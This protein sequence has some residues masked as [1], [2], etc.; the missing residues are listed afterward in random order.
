MFLT[1]VDWCIVAGSMATFIFVAWYTNRYVKSTADFLVAN[2]CAG[3]YL[4]TMC[5]GMASMGAVSIIAMMQMTYKTG[6]SGAM[7]GYL[8]IPVVL[9][10][11]L[12]GWV[13]YR[14]RETRAMTMGE[15]FEKRVQ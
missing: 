4:L 11:R 8:G 2:R 10:L 13:Q 15:F 1:A 9:L 14:Y 6:L 5:D 7:W 12:T 3:R